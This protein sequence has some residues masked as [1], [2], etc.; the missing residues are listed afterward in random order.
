MTDVYKRQERTLAG[1]YLKV[2]VVDI[3]GDLDVLY[4]APGERNAEWF[5]GREDCQSFTVSDR[6]IAAFRIDQAGVYTFYA[7][8]RRGND[9]AYTV[10]IADLRD[11][12]KRQPPWRL[13]WSP[14]RRP[15]SGPILTAS[16]RRR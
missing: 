1:L 12:Y 15:W 13:P 10:R 2:R 9:T 5:R 11:V 16:G 6:D 7:R 8:D 14:G 3:D 4:Y